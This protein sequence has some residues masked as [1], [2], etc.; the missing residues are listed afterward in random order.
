M[1]P[2]FGQVVAAFEQETRA[3]LEQKKAIFG[4]L[5]AVVIDEVHLF[6]GT[7]CGDHLRC[8]LRRIEYMRAYHQQTSG[9]PRSSS[10]RDSLQR[11]ALSATV[12]DSMGVARR[13]LQDVRFRSLLR[14]AEEPLENRIDGLALAESYRFRP[15]VLVQPIFSLL[16]QSPTGAVRLPDLRCI[17]PYDARLGDEHLHAIYGNLAGEG[18]LKGG[19]IGEWR[20]GPALD[21]LLD[22]HEIYRN[23]GSDPLRLM[24]VDAFSG[25]TIAQT[26][27]GR[28]EGDTLLL[29]GRSREV[30]WRDGY[31]IGVR[32]GSQA[33]MDAMMQITATPFAVPL[34]VSRGVAAYLD[35]APGQLCAHSP[36]HAAQQHH[37]APP[38][39]RPPPV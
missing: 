24:I 30:V 36:A 26:D 18:Y 20:S 39:S 23:I 34:D 32:A 14:V 31:R 10:Q 19:R 9:Q 7:P 25:R 17:T 11:V 12:D 29:G 27:R 38:M 8:L 22:A 28:L 6:D 2:I 37:L 16:K 15:S 1:T 3:A 33:T 13:Y 4:H 21:E 35:L 5:R